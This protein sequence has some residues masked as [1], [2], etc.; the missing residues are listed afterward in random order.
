MRAKRAAGRVYGASF[1]SAEKKAMDME[2]QRQLAEYDRKHEL[3][4]DAMV[5]WVLHVT[6]GFGEKRLK[7]FYDG[8]APA[9]DALI[10]RYD[11]DDSDQVWLCTKQLKEHG[12]DISKWHDERRKT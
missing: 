1:T 10:H 6:E 5:L 8:F 9:L 7:R 12:I 3:E 11:M 4:I 2:I